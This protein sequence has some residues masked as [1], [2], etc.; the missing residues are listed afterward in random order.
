MTKTEAVLLHAHHKEAVSLGKT[1]MLEKNNRQQEKS[2]TNW[3]MD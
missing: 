3:E 2:K 1:I